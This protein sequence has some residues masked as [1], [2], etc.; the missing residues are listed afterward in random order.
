MKQP[1][2]ELL[3][4]LLHEEIEANQ[5]QQ[6]YCDREL[7]NIAILERSIVDMKGN[8]FGI[9]E[10][11]DQDLERI[12]RIA[13]QEQASEVLQQL[14]YIRSLYRRLGTGKEH[15]FNLEMYKAE[16][17]RINETLQKRVRSSQK[18]KE[19]MLQ[20]KESYQEELKKYQTMLELIEKRKKGS[21]PFLYLLLPK[22]EQTVKTEQEKYQIC[23]ELL[24]FNNQEG[25]KKRATLLDKYAALKTAELNKL[26]A[27]AI[28]NKIA[29]LQNKKQSY[30]TFVETME[31]SN[32]C[33]RK[34]QKR[35]F[36]FIC[37]F[38]VE[39]LGQIVCA[40]KEYLDL[41]LS[42]NELKVVQYLVA[43]MRQGLEI[44]L[45]EEQFDTVNLLFRTIEN[46]QL[47]MKQRQ[48]LLEESLRSLG[49]EIR[50]LQEFE[51]QIKTSFHLSDNEVL[52]QVNYFFQTNDISYEYQYCFMKDFLEQKEF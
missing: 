43:G 15:S 6:Q 8:V 45:T 20:Q 46:I 27:T 22:I 38:S 21:I 36:D 41:E 2:L 39:E 25:T 17:G 18:I 19:R 29:E 3:K 32:A 16:L 7:D 11:S 40:A 34:I 5:K 33:Y 24:Q 50:K 48:K 52:K 35:S 44:T 31:F 28:K 10:F 30:T 13:F 47:E 14:N 9:L 51:K 37:N 4:K 12:V 49:V 23:Y 42:L 26:I 1:I